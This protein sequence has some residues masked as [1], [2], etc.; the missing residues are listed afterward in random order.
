MSSLVDSTAQFETQ[1]QDTGLGLPLVTSLKTHGVRTL[2]QLAFTVGQP[3]QPIADASI[4]ALIQAAAGRAPTLSETSILKRVAFEAQTYLTATLRQ[5]V[6]RTDD[7]PRRIPMAERSTR[8][9][10]LKANLAGLSIT[11]ELEPAH[12]VLDK[13]CN[14]YEANT[15]KYMDLASCISRSFEIQSSNTKNKELTLERGSLVVKAAEGPQAATDSEIKVHYAFVRRGVAFQFAKLMSYSQHA[16]WESFLFEALHREP[17]P[18][19][20]RPSLA[21]LLQCD[22]AAFSRLGSVLSSI[23]QRDD[24]TFPLGLALLDLR[25]DPHI[26]LYLMPTSRASSATQQHGPAP[27]ESNPRQQPYQQGAYNSRPK[28][29]GKGKQG[30]GKSSP[31]VPQELRGKWHKSSSGEPICFGFNCRSGCP[32]KNVKPG[33]RCSKGLHICAE[34]K[35]GGEHSLQQHGQK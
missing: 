9:E 32:E 15:L 17:P 8:M 6:D 30:G 35:C 4:E 34:P 11:G 16:Q 33:Q 2:A 26:A 21:Q 28:G 23:K 12:C 31:P 10:A 14:M 22:K 19:F 27:R 3:G 20:S 7:A 25:N 18:H 24:G 29:F 13:M 5:A 1:L